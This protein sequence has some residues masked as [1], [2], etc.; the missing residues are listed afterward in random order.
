MQHVMQA[1]QGG[2]TLMH[3][4]EDTWTGSSDKANSETS[5]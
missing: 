3:L 4:V 2:G 5:E 1:V